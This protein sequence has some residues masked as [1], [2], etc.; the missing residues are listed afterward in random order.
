MRAS[1]RKGAEAVAERSHYLVGEA[2]SGF[3]NEE[4][5]H[6]EQDHSG[7]RLGAGGRLRRSGVR[8]SDD[9]WTRHGAVRQLR[10]LD[11]PVLRLTHLQARR[12]PAATAGHLR[13]WAEFFW[14]LH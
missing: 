6:V 14:L 5:D 9:L 7:S 1:Y 4:K 8:C 2:V 11:R 10:H 12:R 13:R 3:P